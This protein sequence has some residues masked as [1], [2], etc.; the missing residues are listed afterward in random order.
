MWKS[1]LPWLAVLVCA[2]VIVVQ[3]TTIVSLQKKMMHRMC[4]RKGYAGRMITLDSD[5]SA[6]LTTKPTIPPTH[7]ATMTT[8]AIKKKTAMPRF[9]TERKRCSSDV[10]LS[11]PLLIGIRPNT[12]GAALRD[13]HAYY[14]TEFDLGYSILAFPSARSLNHS[15][16]KSIFTLPYPFHG[17]DNTVYNRTVY[18]SYDNV[19][20][21]FNMKTGDTKELRLNASQTYK[22]MSTGLWVLYRRKGEEFLTAS[23]VQPASLKAILPNRLCNAF[24]R[25]GLLYTVSCDVDHVTVSA[26]YDFYAHMYVSTKQS[27]WKG[28]TSLSSVQ[29]DPNSK[30]ITI[31]DNG[32]I[33]TVIAE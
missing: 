4:L 13:G 6:E 26:A 20:I 3:R 21:S 24:I 30:S 19:V 18:Y 2:A 14:V 31:S 29:Y 23:R 11:N 27:E 32:K 10:T 17:T 9:R 28:M 22:L 1:S 16:P 8:R 5:M 7:L 25:C 33:Y 12:I 15:E